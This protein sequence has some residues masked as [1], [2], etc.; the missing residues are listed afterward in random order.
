M[1]SGCTLLESIELPANISTISE[2]AFKNCYN[3]MN[4]TLLNDAMDINNT[5][6]S[7]CPTTMT[8]HT[9]CDSATTKWA[10]EKGYKV[11]KSDHTPVT[12]P[13]VA[14]TCGK[15][16]LT[17]GTHCSVCN[18]V[19]KAQE[20]VPALAHTPVTDPAVAPTCTKTG[21]TEGS[22]CSICNTIIKAQEVVPVTEHTPATDPAVAPTCTKT[23]LME[24]SHCSICGKT[25][26]KQR[27]VAKAEHT[28]VID[29]AVAPTCTRA[30]KT[31]G[32]HCSVCGKVFV[33][34]KKIPKL[35]SLKKCNITGIK[36]AV[37]IG[38]AIKPS[39]VVKYN[40][41]KLVKGTD[42]T[43]KYAN[44]KAVGK[45][46]VTITGVGKYG[47]SVSK[48]FTINPKAVALTGLTAGK[49][50]LTVKWKKGKN[51]TGYQVQYSLKKSFSAA[52]TVTIKKA[53]TVKAV[54]KKLKTGK[55]WYVRVRTYK[56]VKGK[57]YYSAWSK[58]KSAKVK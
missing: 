46:T 32:T 10:E 5:A 19:I 37:Y 38:K 53:A 52:K 31:A 18:A 20:E 41:K 57:K 39:P 17:E 47:E 30:G 33:K 43:V 3:L 22:H 56:T 23:G 49:Q 40:G 11:V 54:L 16:G 35:I 55:T 29:E 12:D 45:A 4:V 8:F 2:S 9:P 7:G 51:I 42:Y 48:T 28:Y 25:L 6:F 27:T 15:S 1:F 34:Q 26:V 14:P 36:D 44:N 21:L 13:A 50:Q 58:A 24:G